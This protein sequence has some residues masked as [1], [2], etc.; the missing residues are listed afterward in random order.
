MPSTAI[1]I[2]SGHRIGIRVAS[3]SYPNYEV[4]PNTWDAVESY[5]QAQVA[6][7]SVHVAGDH[8]S[9]V[10]LPVV[11]AGSVPE[12]VAKDTN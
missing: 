1:V 5:N 6:K 3:S 11:D 7:N 8:A 10:V 9:R 2:N 12:F 4:H